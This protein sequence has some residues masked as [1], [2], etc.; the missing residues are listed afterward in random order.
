V[1]AL[2]AVL[3]CR[4]IIS[5]FAQANGAMGAAVLARAL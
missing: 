4:I 5:A 2:E 3:E 1:A